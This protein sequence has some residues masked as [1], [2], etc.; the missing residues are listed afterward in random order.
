[1]KLKSL[2]IGTGLVVA[3]SISQTALS[4]AAGRGE[5][6]PVRVEGKCAAW[7]PTCG[8]QAVAAANAESPVGQRGARLVQTGI[9]R[10]GL[11]VKVAS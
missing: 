8:V 11:H 5:A 9:C 10:K 3:A 6:P 7:W 4:A 1:M 2:L